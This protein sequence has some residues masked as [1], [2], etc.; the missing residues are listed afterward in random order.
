MT[1]IERENR[2]NHTCATADKNDT[3]LKKRTSREVEVNIFGT[4]CS[5]IH[6]YR[7]NLDYI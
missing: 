5:D 1:N 4:K 7:I 6:T 2:A 3:R